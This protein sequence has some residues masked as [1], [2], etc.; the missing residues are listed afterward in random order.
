MP[1]PGV[2]V[3][4]AGQ[5]AVQLAASLRQ[6]GYA[7]PITLVG[8]EPGLPYQRPPLSKAYMT[9]QM[10]EAGL[11]LRPGNFYEQQRID[12]LTDTRATSI[13]RATKRV[14]LDKG[15]PITYENLVLATGARNRLLPN[16]EGV[17]TLRTK[18]EA[19][20]LRSRLGTAEKIVVI[21]AGF[22]GL[23]FAAVAAGRGAQVT[24]IEMAPGV[25]GRAVSKPMADHVAA[26]HGQWGSEI[27]TNTGVTRAT[28]TTVETT[29]GRTL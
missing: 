6:G 22:I 3:I 12:L 23:E 7:E 1:T 24:I 18:A 26:V 2:V 20:F 17:A 13:D 19:D 25:M 29:I 5:A 28:A 15:A 8:D 10:D 14:H 16:A 27:L 21:G 9:G 11:L 4:G